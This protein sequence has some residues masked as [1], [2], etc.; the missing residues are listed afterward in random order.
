MTFCFSASAQFKQDA[1]SQTYADPNDTTAV[2]SAAVMFSVKNFY[3]GIHH[4]EPVKIGTVFA[5]STVYIGGYQ[6]HNRQTWKLPIIYG[7]LAA[8]AGSGLYYRNKFT[9]SLDNYHSALDNG[10][11]TLPE[12]DRQSQHISNYLFAGA[13][14]I[15][16]ATLADGVTN[17]DKETYPHPGK[18]TLYSI[19]CPGLGQ[20][21]NHEF[22]KL[23]IYWG[24]LIGS[25]HYYSTFKTN[26]EK[27]R[28]IY[29]DA[30][31]PDIKYDGPISGQTALYYRN[32][33]R[34]YRDY[35]I[36]AMAA[37]YLLQVIDANVF[38]Y[39]QDFE[40]TDDLSMSV[41][42][43]LITPNTAL[44]WSPSSHNSAVGISLGFRF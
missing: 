1:F 11:V 42:P 36:L 43:T 7:G 26:Y 30:N 32:I 18:A 24:G 14:A 5:G 31:N 9:T 15:Y 8:T 28:T 27:Y 33:Y 3:R 20:I 40:M 37:F 2:D 6:I 10:S 29:N 12:I 13:A 4:K 34:R 23:P 44:A 21:Y 41:T 22:W 16:W 19:L 25:Y 35:S 39:M 17:F 38:A